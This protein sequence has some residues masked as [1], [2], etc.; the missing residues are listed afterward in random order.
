MR[1]VMYRTGRTPMLI[2]MSVGFFLG[3]I[4][5]LIAAPMMPYYPA[6]GNNVIPFLGLAGTIFLRILTVIIVPLVFSSL[7]VSVASTG[8]TRKV[9][10][11]GIKTVAL[12]L[13]T[14]IIAA[15]IGILSVNIFK[16]G[17]S[18]NIPAAING[19]SGKTLPTQDLFLNLFPENFM[20]SLFHIN[21]LHLIITAVVIG[22]ACI[23]FGDSSKKFIHF[24]KKVTYIM[25][26]VTYHVMIF[27]PLGVF[28][29]AATAA[30]DFGLTLIA[31]FA[32]IIAA[33]FLGSIVHALAVYSP[34]IILFCKKSPKWFF[35]GV[36]EAAITGFAT[37]SSAVTLPV[38]FADVRENLG[39]SDEV[40][41]FVLPLGA[42]INMDG[43]AIY[44]VVCAMFVAR[45]FNVPVTFWLQMSIFTA[46]V[47]ASIGTAGVP[48]GGMIMLTMVLTSAG[49]P[50]E[51]VGLVAGI[52]VV[53]G[54]ARTCLNVIGD[55]AV[56]VSV[57]ASE[58]ED[59]TH[60]NLSG[61]MRGMKHGA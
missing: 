2:K 7:I 14:T 55:C 54:P 59:L 51:A 46:A 37:R 42:T 60:P 16:P 56:C 35:N 22:L 34:M 50:V 3:I 23:L 18:I 47:I 43:T 1:Q 58:G 49:L 33:V 11:V 38:T 52:D 29:L 44:Q 31:P 30:E 39:V 17:T 19:Y 9:G 48:S 6:L 36:R 32:K 4:F 28:A 61:R 53:L 27:A 15:G 26:N 12:F 13:I 8:D 24:F 5:G 45:S 21:M 25:Q 41:S 20:T 40:S 10:R 57:A